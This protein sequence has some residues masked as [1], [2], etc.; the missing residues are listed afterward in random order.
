[1][2]VYDGINC[3]KQSPVKDFKGKGRPLFNVYLGSPVLRKVFCAAVDFV[4]F[5]L[6]GVPYFLSRKSCRFRHKLNALIRTVFQHSTSVETGISFSIVH[7]SPLWRN[8]HICVMSKIFGG[9][10]VTVRLKC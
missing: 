8:M 1:M 2:K 7:K 6:Q 5:A 3:K 4:G 9:E 10:D